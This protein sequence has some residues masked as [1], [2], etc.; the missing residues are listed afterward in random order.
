MN[1]S[2]DILLLISPLQFG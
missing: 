2:H 1:F